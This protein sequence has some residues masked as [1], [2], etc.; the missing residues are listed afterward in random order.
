M[1]NNMFTR[2]VALLLVLVCVV[3]VLPAPVSAA[4]G[5]SSAPASI[6]QQTC[7]FMKIGGQVV[8]YESASSVINSYGQPS[9]FDEQMEVPGYGTTRALC[10]KFLGRLSSR[11]NGQKWNFKQEVSSSSL[12]TI[13][14]YIYSCTY[15]DFTEAGNARGLSH[16][17]SY[18]SDI[19][20]MVAQG[21]SWYYEYGI[22]LDVSADR[23]AFIEQ[24]AAEFVAA[25]KLYHQTYGQSSWITNWDDIGT[26]SIID[27]AD[28]GVTGYSAY[29]YVATGVNL[30]LDHPEYFHSY[31]LWLYEWDTSQPWQLTG[32]GVMQTLLIAIPDPEH[33]E[34]ES[35]SLTVKKLEAGTNHP[36]PGVTFVIES[37]DGSGDF[38]VTRQTGPDGTF[39]LTSEADGLSPDQYR[40]TETAAPEGYCIQC[41]RGLL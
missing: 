17:N 28:G 9:V 1:K 8:H 2:A 10:A 12:K 4:G 18:W 40:I 38:S 26:H 35:V 41:L 16:W 27:S 33:D 19:W 3:G 25:M 22:L 37:A 36:V 11:A 34:D 7:D 30:V 21:L 24:A 14:T 29:D 13:L 20:F 6:T 31:H 15:G 23:E 39:T 5:L 32:D